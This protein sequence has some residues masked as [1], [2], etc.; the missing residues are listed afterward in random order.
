MQTIYEALL[1]KEKMKGRRNCEIRYARHKGTY[2]ELIEEARIRN[3]E[4]TPLTMREFYRERKATTP[5]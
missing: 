5:A 2:E 4:L 1:S 3:I